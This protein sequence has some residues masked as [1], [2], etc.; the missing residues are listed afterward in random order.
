MSPETI[1]HQIPVLQESERIKSELLSI[2]D[3]ERGIAQ[4][5]KASRLEN[6]RELM[7]YAPVEDSGLD[8][9][10]DTRI[11]GKDTVIPPEDL[12]QVLPASRN[13]IETTRTAREDISNILDHTDDRIVAIVGPCSIHDPE[14]A[15][16]YGEQVK[17]WRHEYGDDLEVIMR[18]YPEKPRSGD[19]WKGF[20]VDPLLDGSEDMNLGVV[21]TR[22][23]ACQLTDNGIPLATE[24]LNTNTPQF[25]NGLIAYDAIGARNAADQKSR[26]YLS[27]TSSVGGIKNPQDG[28][29]GVAV[30]GVIAANAPHTFLGMDETG[31]L[32]QVRTAGNKSAHVILRGS[33]AGP[34]FSASYIDET[35]QLLS[36]KKLTQS[37]VVDASHGNSYKKADQQIECVEDVAQQIS[38]GETAICGVMIESNLKEGK[39]PHKDKDGSFRPKSELE[40]GVSITDECV[41]LKQT[42]RILEI[43]QAAVKKRREV[44]SRQN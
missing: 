3:K 10:V 1:A 26:E 42:E 20:I 27:G 37:I 8:Q 36:A 13:S 29:I 39:Q 16:Q 6:L 32:T 19:D 12:A 43:L 38:L 22:M 33:D 7:G 30:Q 41:D 31:T 9:V 23:I 15:L 44:N 34:N 2:E 11:V 14:Q 35:K 21:A 28:N 25:I 17:A 24:R 4:L 18:F 40:S 5:S